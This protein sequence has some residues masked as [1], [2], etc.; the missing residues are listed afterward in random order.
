MNTSTTY[1]QLKDAYGKTYGYA[2]FPTALQFVMNHGC[3]AIRQMC[4][5][6]ITDMLPD[7]YKSDVKDSIAELALLLA[8]TD[9]EVILA[10][11]Q[12]DSLPIEDE[13]RLPPLHP[14]GDKEGICPICGGEIDYCGEHELNDTGYSIAGCAPT[15]EP[16]VTRSTVNC[17]PTTPVSAIKTAR[18]W[19]AARTK[20]GI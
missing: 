13:E 19:R 6:D 17:S 4:R 12:R 10:F 1:A 11:A 5:K 16:P 18:K 20:A 15:A 2:A 8:D 9:S 3:D 14:D 7:E